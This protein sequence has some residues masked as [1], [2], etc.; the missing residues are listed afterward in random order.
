MLDF[1]SWIVLLLG[2]VDGPNA[3]SIM[4]N[5][6]IPKSQRDVKGYSKFA[7]AVRFR[8]DAEAVYDTLSVFNTEP[9]TWMPF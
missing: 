9:A 5:R 3:D 6:I 2:A 7:E 1:S 8:N 4:L